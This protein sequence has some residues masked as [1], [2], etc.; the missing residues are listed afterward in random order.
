M[1]I[2]LFF[3][4]FWVETMLFFFFFFFL[5]MEKM[6]IWVWHSLIL[7]VSSLY[8]SILL[9]LSCSYDE[10]I[11]LMLK[12]RKFIDKLIPYERTHWKI[13]TP[14][15]F[16]SPI[17]VFEKKPFIG[18]LPKRTGGPSQIRRPPAKETSLD[19]HVS[20]NRTNEPTMA[21]RQCKIDTLH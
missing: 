14:S 1:L 18:I 7:L 9:I 20:V 3:S 16:F 12:I 6:L 8:A 19:S 10:N 17:Y 13:L 15:G 5:W 11:I 21:G 2:W 4:F